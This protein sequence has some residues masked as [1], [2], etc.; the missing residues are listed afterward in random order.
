MKK[1]FF[2]R[3]ICLAAAG[4]V[5]CSALIAAAV[6]GSPY[7]VLKRSL[8]DLSQM[9]D[10][11][12]KTEYKVFLDGSQ[13]GEESQIAFQG[14][15]RRLNYSGDY[16]YM[17][18]NSEAFNLNT[19][20]GYED[21]EIWYSAQSPGYERDSSVFNLG[22]DSY[23]RF[24][25]LLLDLVVGD[26]KNNV[27]MNQDGDIRNISGTLT[28]AQIPELYNAA[29]EFILTQNAQSRYSLTY[30][31]VV[32]FDYD[33]NT[34]VTKNVYLSGVDRISEFYEYSVKRVSDP[35]KEGYSLKHG[36]RYYDYT[37]SELLRTDTEPAT[38]EDYESL[39][40]SQ[41][42]EGLPPL[43]K[44]RFTYVH[45]DA[46]VDS[47]GNLK[48]IRGTVSADVTDIFGGEHEV[49]FTFDIEASDIGTTDPECPIAGVEELLAMYKHKDANYSSVRFKL[50]GDGSIDYGSVFDN[51]SDIEANEKY[52]NGDTK[53][54]RVDEYADGDEDSP[55]DAAAL[56][57]ENEEEAEQ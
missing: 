6:S 26:L 57:N 46:S 32:S 4:L 50:N 10:L 11:T 2:A 15:K 7:E 30:N 45:G 54:L 3:L 41:T 33:N 37:D 13:V 29:L 1:S 35:D 19:W 18:Y 40:Y 55:E 17:S 21:G 27:S 22:S 14:S 52:N 20:G 44:G 49:E 47:E 12:L 8:L 9:K 56:E 43:A 23:S 38:P 34:C 31:E 42:L 25:E 36:G 51:M 24:A 16:D 48:T 39:Q 28:A 5:L 53:V